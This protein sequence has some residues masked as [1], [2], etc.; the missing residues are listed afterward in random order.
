MEQKTWWK[1]ITYAP[2]GWTTSR[3]SRTSYGFVAAR[4]RSCSSSRC[5]RRPTWMRMLLLRAEPDPL[6]P[7]V[8]RDGRA[9]TGGDLDVLVLLPRARQG[10]RPLRARRPATGCTR[11]TSRS[12]GSPRTCRRGS[13]PSARKFVEWMPKAIDD[14]ETLLT[15]AARSGSSGRRASAC[16]RPTTRSR[17]VSPGRCCARRASTGTSAATSRTSRTPRSTSTSPSTRAAT[18]TT[19]TACAWT[20][21]ASRCGSSTSASTGSMPGRRRGSP[22]TARSCCR[23]ARSSTPRWSR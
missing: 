4:S 20:R 18:S 23:R 6:A 9:R 13:S 8:A 3:S 5:R 1:A 17:S 10:A 14:Y 12:A 15:N 22:T 21:C 11:G 19:D 2:S 16:C 7:R